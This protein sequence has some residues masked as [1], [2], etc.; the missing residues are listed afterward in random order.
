M[1]IKTTIRYHFITTMMSVILENS[2]WQVLMR[3]QRNWNPCA[4]LL[5]VWHGV[6]AVE[7]SLADPLTVKHRATSNSTSR[8]IPKRHENIGL[9]KNLYMNVHRSI[10]RKSQKVETAP[11]KDCAWIHKTWY[12]LLMEYYWVLKGREALMSVTT[13]MN[14]GNMLNERN[15]WSL[16]ETVSQRPRVMWYHLCEK[17]QVSLETEQWLGGQGVVWK[18]EWLLMGLGFLS[19]WWKFSKMYYRD[20]CATL[21]IY[22]NLLTVYIGEWYGMW[23]LSHWSCYAFFLRLFLITFLEASFVFFAH[24]FML[25][26]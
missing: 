26:T 9:H 25:C 21:W 22:Q 24:C 11:V 18:W 20:G 8:F 12:S 5:G 13:R 14:S 3:I 2:E 19:G 17:R 23:I 1:Q 6:A 4:V 16:W 15:E 10:F 7:D